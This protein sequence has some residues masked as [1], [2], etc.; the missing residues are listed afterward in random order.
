M[1]DSST[2]RS[3]PTWLSSSS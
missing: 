2:C 3:L 1:S